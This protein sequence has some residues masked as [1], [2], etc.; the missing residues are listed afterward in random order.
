[1][2]SASYLEGA[3]TLVVLAFEE[4]VDLWFRWCLPLEWSA[5]EGF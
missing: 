3:N 2:E 1:M 5:N 4:E